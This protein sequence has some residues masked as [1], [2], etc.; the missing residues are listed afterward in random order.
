M[1]REPMILEGRGEACMRAIADSIPDSVINRR[2]HLRD[3][4]NK[5]GG[6]QNVRPD[7][8][9][10]LCAKDPEDIAALREAGY[11]AG[12]HPDPSNS[13]A[14]KANENSR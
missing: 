11:P 3:L 12:N 13:R 8:L 7:T 1:S 4:I 9:F 5:A 14:V 6:R 10:A 2:P